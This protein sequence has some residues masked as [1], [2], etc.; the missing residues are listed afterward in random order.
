MLT[1]TDL[2]EDAF[3]LYFLFKAAKRGLKR[4]V[5]SDFDLW[6]VNHLFLDLIVLQT[7]SIASWVEHVNYKIIYMI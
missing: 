5:F 7:N 2:F 1:V 3:L 4:L 6:Q